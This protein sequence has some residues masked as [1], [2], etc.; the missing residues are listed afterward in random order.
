MPYA[1]LTQQQHDAITRYANAHGR[2][3]KAALREEWMN[4]C[5]DPDLQMLRNTHGPS[6]LVG[7]RLPTTDRRNDRF[8][9]LDADAPDVPEGMRPKL[10]VEYGCGQRDCGAC[11]EPVPAVGTLENPLR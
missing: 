8:P 1:P 6:W 5:N 4:G 2:T 9:Q 10:G 3:W 7:Y 11:Y